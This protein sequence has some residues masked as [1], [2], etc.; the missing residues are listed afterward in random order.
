MYYH[1]WNFTTN[2]NAIALKKEK[3]SIYVSAEPSNS[4]KPSLEIT[5][6]QDGQKIDKFFNDLNT[7]VLY[8]EGRL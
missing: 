8:C 6:F 4:I 7:A 2:S 1:N 5:V 3:F